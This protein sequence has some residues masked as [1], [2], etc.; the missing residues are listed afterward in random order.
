MFI[1]IVN[2]DHI[3]FYRAVSFHFVNENNTVFCCEGVIW[4]HLKQEYHTFFCPL[5]IDSRKN[6]RN[7]DCSQLLI[8]L[9]RKQCFA[10]V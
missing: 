4:C 5:F 2:C 8:A 6:N 9:R 10:C 7:F 1:S 3:K